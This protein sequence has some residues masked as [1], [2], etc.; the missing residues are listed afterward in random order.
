M[1]LTRKQSALIHVA[2]KQL[3]LADADYRAILR[4]EAGVDSSRDLD[5]DGFQSVLRQF[6]RLGFKQRGARSLG[7]RAGM[8][9][10][11]Q[12]AY[13]RKLWAEYTD[14]KGDDRSLGKWLNRT[15]KV[16]DIRFV[17][18]RA[19]SK[20]ITGLLAMVEKKAAADASRPRG[21]A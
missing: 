9:S 17:G 13:I 16:S 7:W 1:S 18:Y 8:A 2:R 4:A 3:A 11:A 5:A 14:G 19:A 10:P 20:A 15:V 6:K 12:V 21:A